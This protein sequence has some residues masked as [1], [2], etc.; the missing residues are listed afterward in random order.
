MRNRVG[1]WV[2]ARAVA[3]VGRRPDL[4]RGFVENMLDFQHTEG[5]DSGMVPRQHQIIRSFDASTDLPYRGNG[6]GLI[7]LETEHDAGLNRVELPGIA[8]QDQAGI[9]PDGFNESTHQ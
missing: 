5:P 2:H 9:R 3:T 1:G 6:P 8:N 7:I 4:A